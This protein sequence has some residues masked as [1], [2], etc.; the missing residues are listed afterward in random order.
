MMADAL[1]TIKNTVT[2]TEMA[3]RIGMDY[4][5][6]RGSATANCPFCGDTTGHLYLYRDSGRY[7]CFKCHEKGDLIDLALKGFNMSIESIKRLFGYDTPAHS[8]NAHSKPLRKPISTIKLPAPDIEQK[9]PDFSELYFEIVANM[10]LSDAGREYLIHRGLTNQII[11]RYDLRSIDDPRAFKDSLM[12]KYSAD[13]LFA[14]GL[15]DYSK[16]GKLYC[17]FF[18]PA[19]LFPH[20]D[21]HITK[22]TGLS[23]RNLAGDAKS[24]KLHGVPSSYYYGGDAAQAKEIFVFEGIINALSYAVM[25]DKDNFIATTGLISPAKYNELKLQH[26]SQ[27]LILALDP[28][29]AG[30]QALSQ[31]QTCTYIDW[32]AFAIQLGFKGLQTHE[33]GKAWDMNDYLINRKAT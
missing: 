18:M 27:K 29:D 30:K 4:T 16:N 20:F 8:R 7:Y 12:E 2:I 3:D 21:K 28:D 23:T 26:P 13:D 22:I 31:I 6:R 1:K 10:K 24:F 9:Q 11:D 25:A 32:T 19:I 5:D 33:S 17:S 15:I 14:A